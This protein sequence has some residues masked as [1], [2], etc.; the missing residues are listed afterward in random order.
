[1]VAWTF[2][3]WYCLATIPWAK[4]APAQ[5]WGDM[6]NARERH[7]C[8][9]S[10]YLPAGRR[11]IHGPTKF[12]IV[13]PASDRKDC[14]HQAKYPAK[15]RAASHQHPSSCVSTGGVGRATDFSLRF[16]GLIAQ[17]RMVID[18]IWDQERSMS[19]KMSSRSTQ[20]SGFFSKQTL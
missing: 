8:G 11:D 19:Q 5:C 1:M 3:H 9:H 10:A 14:Y 12:K 7:P 2:P 17:I 18:T 20:V 15:E 4:C 13:G 6:A 16:R